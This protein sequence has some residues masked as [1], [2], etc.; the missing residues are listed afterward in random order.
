MSIATPLTFEGFPKI[1]R[2]SR[3]VIITEKIDGTNAQIFIDDSD[4]VLLVGSRN[5]YLSA[6][7]DN[8]G[9][10]KWALE[11][12][13]ELSKLGPGRHYGEW[14]GRG[15]QRGYGIHEKRFSLFNVGRWH[16]K[17]QTPRV[18]RRDFKTG[19][20]LKTTCEAP[21]C[22]RVV[23]ILYEGPMRDGLIEMSM[24]ALENNGSVAAP[25][26]M[27]PEGIVIFHT[28]NGALFKKTFKDDAGKTLTINER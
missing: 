1:G 21:A 19:E 5:R 9:F 28:A 4:T 14:W 22:C 24:R 20:V 25:G 26:F 6:N 3:D 23:P 8:A 7:N 11:H 17:G 27:V 16:E 2:W 13:D 18:V 12:H 10:F 15:I